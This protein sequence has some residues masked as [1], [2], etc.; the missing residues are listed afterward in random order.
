MVVYAVYHNSRLITRFYCDDDRSDIDKYIRTQL[1]HIVDNYNTYYLCTLTIDDVIIVPNNKV[2]EHQLTINVFFEFRYMKL[3]KQRIEELPFP[4]G[5]QIKTERSKRPLDDDKQFLPI[6]ENNLKLFFSA[7]NEKFARQVAK[8]LMISDKSM[9]NV[10]CQYKSDSRI[11]LT[12][13]QPMAYD[14]M[15]KEERWGP[16][17]IMNQDKPDIGHFSSNCEIR[18]WQ[19]FKYLDRFRDFV[20]GVTIPIQGPCPFENVGLSTVHLRYT[21]R[22]GDID[23][24]ERSLQKL[25]KYIVDNV[26]IDG[27]NIVEK[28]RGWIYNPPNRTYYLIV[29]DLEKKIVRHTLNNIAIDNISMLDNIINEGL[30]EIV[31]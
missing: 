12:C 7:E 22:N 17:F 23:N 27:Y 1:L 14:N 29:L 18:V 3:F 19:Q 28:S 25:S 9:L 24:E 2:Y 13:L 21:M 15:T 16:L 8:W 11:V 26:R 30:Q 10:T 5:L 20:K 6:Y 31:V 4:K